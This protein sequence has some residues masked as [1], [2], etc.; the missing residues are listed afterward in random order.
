MAGDGTVQAKPIKVEKEVGPEVFVSAGLV[1]NE[2]IIVGDQL[3]EIKVGDRVE[4][5]GR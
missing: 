4:V 3:R 1:G 5:R 2:A